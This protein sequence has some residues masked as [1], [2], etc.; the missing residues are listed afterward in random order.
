VT[1][2]TGQGRG[3]YSRLAIDALV[4][5]VYGALDRNDR[6]FLNIKTDPYESC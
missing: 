1:M 4:S 3:I 5:L 2:I 6:V